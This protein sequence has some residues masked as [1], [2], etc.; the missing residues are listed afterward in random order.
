MVDCS[1]VIIT[2]RYSGQNPW[3]MR[4]IS[5]SFMLWVFISKETY[6]TSLVVIHWTVKP[7]DMSTMKSSKKYTEK[8]KGRLWN[9]GE[10]MIRQRYSRVKTL[11]AESQPPSWSGRYPVLPQKTP[12]SGHFLVPEFDRFF[13]YS[14]YGF[15]FKATR[16]P[17]VFFRF[18]LNLEI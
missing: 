13:W 7:F 10:T 6:G 11:L 14:K 4:W 15:L 9:Y 2:E 5:S 16:A 8:P 18:E 1:N 3:N 12:A 17:F